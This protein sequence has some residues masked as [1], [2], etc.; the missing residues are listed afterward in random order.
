M[1][2]QELIEGLDSDDPQE[3]E[4]AAIALGK[5]G[6]QAVA[7]VPALISVVDDEDEY[8]S[9]ICSA[10][11]ALGEIGDL[12]AA[13]SLSNTWKETDFE[14]E[15]RTAAYKALERISEQTDVPVD[16]LLAME[17]TS[18]QRSRIISDP[19]TAV[20]RYQPIKLGAIL[21]GGSAGI[22][23]AV[24]GI[25]PVALFTSTDTTSFGIIFIILLF[26]GMLSYLL[27]GFTAG[28]I[29]GY[30]GAIHGGLAAIALALLSMIVS[31][32]GM[33][34]S[35]TGSILAFLI[36]MGVA[37]AIAGG[38]GA[39]G[40]ALGVKFINRRGRDYF[41]LRSLKRSSV[42]TNAKQHFRTAT[43]LYKKGQ[44]A[45]S[46]GEFNEAIRL[47]PNFVL[48]YSGRAFCYVGQ[49]NHGRAVEDFN[50][51][52]R[53]NPEYKEAYYNR[54]C[55]HSELKEYKLA[56][57]NFDEAIR[58]DPEYEK[59]FNNRGYCY[60]ELEEHG[61]AIEDYSEAIRLNPEYKKA[62]ANRAVTYTY[63]HMDNEAQQDVVKAIELGFD[64]AEL[65]GMIKEAKQKS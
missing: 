47:D 10:A 39:L 40:G 62:Y 34:T 43:G 21:L 46:I 22:V 14:E 8:L 5:H 58:L 30:R 52:I 31:L 35:D 17:H 20:I 65:E 57:E 27:G 23:V 4:Q 49:G 13:G 25:V 33:R 55:C 26:I 56:I 64:T 15:C 9:V 37:C 24:I 44:F 53:L 60:D 36:G 63:M 32:I 19:S 12:S 51:A 1:W 18:V 6:H 41:Y 45:E 3:R 16:D 48:A 29:A 28:V 54:G 61:R 11:W 7:A 42:S 50:E 2:V 59:S 38:V